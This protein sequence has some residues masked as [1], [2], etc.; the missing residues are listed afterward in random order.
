MEFSA[1]SQEHTLEFEEL[2]AA[3]GSE[4]TWNPLINEVLKKIPKVNTVT[5][6]IENFRELIKQ[7]T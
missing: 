7:L 2:Y 5:V 3:K 4:N 1:V 6:W